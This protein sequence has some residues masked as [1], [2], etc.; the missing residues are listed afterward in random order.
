MGERYKKRYIVKIFFYTVS[1]ALNIFKSQ[2]NTLLV[3]I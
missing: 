2:H 1:I 3:K